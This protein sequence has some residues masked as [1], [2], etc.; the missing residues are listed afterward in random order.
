MEA[1]AINPKLRWA[2]PLVFAVVM[3]VL[4]LRAIQAWPQEAPALT[5][6]PPAAI[7]E[8]T[9]SEGAGKDATASSQPAVPAETRPMPVQKT[10]QATPTLHLPLVF[11]QSTVGRH[12]LDWPQLQM[13]PQRSGYTPQ[14][15]N[16]PITR[17]WN[18][19][20]APERVAPWVQAVIA[21]DRLFIGTT[22]GALYAFDARN[23]SVLW[24]YQAG[25]ILHT[26]G[27]AKGLVFFG[28]MDGNV[29]ALRASSGE[30]A[31]KYESGLRTGFSSAVL[32]A[33]DKVFLANRG[34][35]YFALSQADGR[36]VW[37]RDLGVPILMSSAYDAGR[38]FFGAMDMRVRALKAS[39]GEVLWT[40]AVIPG[41]AFKDYW[42]VVHQGYVLFSPWRVEGSN[43]P[44][45]PLPDKR[46]LLDEN[47]FDDQACVD[48]LEQNPSRKNL[49]VL[50]A[51]T[52]AEA[53]VVPH[54][55]SMAL[56]GTTPPPAVD[57]AGYLI[58]PAIVRDH[59]GGW[60]RLD[61]I[62]RT[63][64]EVLWDDA[65]YKLGNPTESLA[66]SVAGGLVMTFH[67]QEFNAQ[68]TGVWD[69]DVRLWTEVESYNAE[70]YFS[71]NTQGGGASP[72]SVS[73]GIIFHVTAYNTLNARRASDH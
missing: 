59:R 8:E 29:Y 53:F 68:F 17:L 47:D 13:T 66:A 14:D 24:R 25:P 26:A 43:Y 45:C 56:N 72:P 50:D 6:A 71:S 21:E 7:P 57:R 42:P 69:Q 60:A 9:S 36:L 38:I 46:G 4:A 18:H 40:S 63:I 33:E 27:T 19:G 5:W 39:N 11:E 55:I 51:R 30:L 52:G 28:S 70:G 37:K 41:Q 49:F 48:F 54:W 12:G 2:V 20:F 67:T 34:G 65:A 31:W 62:N 61:L 64:V 1:E 23:G 35:V 3:F 32:L 44:H 15:L 10:G 58:V 73:N 22:Q 16:A